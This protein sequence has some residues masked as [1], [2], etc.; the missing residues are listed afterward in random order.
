M[1]GAS[2][3]RVA[4]ARHAD[5]AV[6][7]QQPRAHFRTRV[8]AGDAGFQ[9]D[10]AGAQ[11]AAVLVELGDEAQHHA[12]CFTGDAIDEPRPEGF[13]KT[14]AGTHRELPR[15][16]FEIERALWPQ[17]GFRL[18]QKRRDAFTQLE[19]PRRRHQ[20]PAGAHQ[21]RIA[22]DLAQAG[23]GAARGRSRQSEPPRGACDTTLGKQGVEG[24]EQIEVGT[25]HRRAER[26]R[27]GMTS[28]AR[29]ECTPR[30]FRTV[31]GVPMLGV[32]G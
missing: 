25:G 15:E 16:V 21:Q 23:E 1:T 12:R 10:H 17:H 20:L 27:S 6:A 3:E 26:T 19:R 18:V 32:S 5:E 2:C 29:M 4:L 28:D 22:G 14:V 8:A 9:I 11:A 24:D 31:A 13:D 30:A 7:E